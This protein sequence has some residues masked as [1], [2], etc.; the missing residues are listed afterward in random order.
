LA[1]IGPDGFGTAA[2][3]CDGVGVC[4]ELGVSVV[5]G[6]GAGAADDGVDVGPAHTTTTSTSESNAAPIA[7]FVNIYCIL[8]IVFIDKALIC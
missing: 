1:F 3:D 7:T 2:G 6:F 4:A 8:L 5:D